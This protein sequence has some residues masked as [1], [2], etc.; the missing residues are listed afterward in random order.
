MRGGASWLLAGLAAD[1]VQGI[2]VDLSSAS[3][4]KAASKIIA[5]DMLSFYTGNQPGD[6]PGNLP[7]PYYWWEAGAMFMH[8]VDYYY[9]KWHNT[10]RL[11]IS[12][13]LTRRANAADTGDTTYNKET[14]Q[15][16]CWQAGT[17]GEF[18]PQNQT[19]DEG[20]DDQAFWAFAAMS[21]AENKYPPPQPGY[22]SWTA[23]AQAVFNLQAGRWDGENCGGGLRWQI[24][25]LNSGYDYKNM[26]AVSLEIT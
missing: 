26:A 8:L 11:S 12:A 22:P 13:K 20:N 23:M 16:I 4:I 17:D 14:T 18:M 19:R 24:T 21:A 6:T 5:N 25:P 7:M 15:A 10:R 9:C 1:L 3:S 2:S